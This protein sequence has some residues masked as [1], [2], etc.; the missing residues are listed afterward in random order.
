M[1]TP[2]VRRR[3]VR[4]AHGCSTRAAVTGGHHE[5][6]QEGTQPGQ[7][8]TRPGHEGT[9]LA[10]DELAEELCTRDAPSPTAWSWAGNMP[11]RAR[12]VICSKS[13]VRLRTAPKG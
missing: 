13:D 12:G 5:P 3:D 2:L 9:Q 11:M 7:E 6:G 1:A 10:P 8:G 4:R